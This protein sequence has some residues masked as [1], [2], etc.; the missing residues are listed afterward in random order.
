M[1]QVRRIRH[2]RHEGHQL[3]KTGD[4]SYLSGRNARG[5]RTDAARRPRAEST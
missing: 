4:V 1:K 5:G 2:L 3:A